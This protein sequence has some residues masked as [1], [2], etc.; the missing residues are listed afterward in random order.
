MDVPLEVRLEGTAVSVAV[1]AILRQQLRQD[2]L[3]RKRELRPPFGG[4]DVWVVEHLSH[5]ARIAAG[6]VGHVEGEELI[7]HDAQPVE[8]DALV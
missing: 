6:L 5:E 1:V 7:E 3:Q 8:V 4:G 2:L